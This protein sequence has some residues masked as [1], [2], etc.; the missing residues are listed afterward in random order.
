MGV[1]YYYGFLYDGAGLRELIQNHQHWAVVYVWVSVS[2]TYFKFYWFMSD[3]F[4][5][6]GKLLIDSE[7]AETKTNWKG[8]NWN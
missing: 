7:I 5:L 4:K 2:N 8:I 6:N 1:C 3:I